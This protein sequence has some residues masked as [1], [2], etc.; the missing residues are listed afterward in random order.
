MADISKITLA[1]GSEYNLKD[2]TAR[3]LIDGLSSATKFLGVTT[4][5]L[6]DGAATN[7]ITINNESVTAAS[8]DI[9][10]YGSAEFIFNGTAWQEF[11]DLSA[12]GTLAY[13]DSA[14][15]TYTPAGTVSKPEFTG[16]SGN[17]SV[18]GT[19]SGSISNVELNTT[20]VNSITNV[21]TLPSCTFPEF[22]V[23]GE[24]LTITA[25]TFNQGTLPT[26]GSNTTVATSVKTQPAFSGSETTST[27]TFTPAG[28]VSQPTFS[29][30]E[31]TVTVS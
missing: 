24:T 8:G 29:G 28:T 23:S 5:V 26:K 16:T 20:T 13:K 17:I 3:S 10:S 12:L 22:T 19:P 30:T 1:D 25:G 18:K 21:G 11:G 15:G 4:T 27:G 6:T 7:P 2:A 9:V 14:S 31:A